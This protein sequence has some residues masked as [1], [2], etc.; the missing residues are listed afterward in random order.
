MDIVFEYHYKDESD[1]LSKSALFKGEI[2]KL[3]KKYNNEH[4]IKLIPEKDESAKTVKIEPSHLIEYSSDI[5]D[6]VMGAFK[7]IFQGK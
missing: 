7:N 1:Y 2:D 5:I 4:F 6:E 3:I